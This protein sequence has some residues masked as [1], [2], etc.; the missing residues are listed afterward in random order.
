[1]ARATATAPMAQAEII[2]LAAHRRLHTGAARDWSREIQQSLNNPDAFM[3]AIRHGHLIDRSDPLAAAI[4]KLA[5]GDE[6]AGRV[7]ADLAINLP[8][9]TGFAAIDPLPYLQLL[10]EHVGANRLWFLHEQV[11]AGDLIRLAAWPE[12]VFWDLIEPLELELASRI[13]STM[14]ARLVERLREISPAF[15]Q[16]PR[17]K[18]TRL[19]SNGALSNC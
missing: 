2:D 4:H 17:R 7:A 19:E 1:M 9:I 6:L 18:L 3:A 13:G 8:A 15:G 14:S 12:A 5:V 10:Q 16:V 11:C